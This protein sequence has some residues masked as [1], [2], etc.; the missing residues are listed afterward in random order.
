MCAPHD[1]V[2]APVW[3]AVFATC[4]AGALAAVVRSRDIG[5]EPG[6]LLAGSAAMLFMIA[7]GHPHAEHGS[8]WAAPAALVLAGACAWHALRCALRLGQGQG[9]G[10]DAAVRSRPAADG[11]RALLGARTGAGAHAVMAVGMGAMLLTALS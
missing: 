6:H 11:R 8:G 1:P 4:T 5:G 10:P 7:S 9:A 2:P 3:S